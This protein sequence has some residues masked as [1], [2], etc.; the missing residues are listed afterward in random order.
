MAEG[1]GIV[2]VGYEG[3]APA[4]RHL[5]T[6]ELMF[7]ASVKAYE[8]ARVDPRR[9]VGSFI[10]CTE[11]L[12]EGWSIADEM[13]PD[14][15]GGARRPVC[16]VP[17]DGIQGIAQA[18]MQIRAGIAEVV[19]VEAH[20]KV[21]DVIDK[22]AV[23]NL[24]LDPVYIRVPGA[25]YNVLAG[26]EMSAF[27]DKTGLKRDDCSE[28]VRLSRDRARRNP[29]AS[30]RGRRTRKK[31]VEDHEPI[32]LPLR[33]FD[34]AEF[35][36]GGVVV[37]LAS[38][39]WARRNKRDIVLIEGVSW[40]SGTPWYEGGPIEYA[41]Y[42]KRSFAEAEK[43]AKLAGGMKNFDV[44]ELDDTYS[45]KLLQ[46][47]RSFDGGRGGLIDALIAS[48][49]RINPSGGSLGV[50]HLIEATGLHRVLECVLQIR[51]EAG[52]NQVKGVKRALAL[53]WRGYP[54]ATGAAVILSR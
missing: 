53:S 28:V 10:S 33:R 17:G 52:G 38:E 7:E 49:P 13:V 2:G 27:L 24:S 19:A 40:R 9:D 42:A 6:R 46:H 41:E 31:G 29:R 50:G 48:R 23:E 1:I 14:Q 39:R 26:L 47:L 15:I 51:G 11:D 3:F 54:S 45:F 21:A 32:S 20:S 44:I 8:D 4:I 18:V 37:V 43:Q 36:E 35:A 25:G 5:S 22:V 30:Y 34:R 16:T 12:W